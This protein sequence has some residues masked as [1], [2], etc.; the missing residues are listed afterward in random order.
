MNKRTIRL[1]ATL[2]ILISISCLLALSDSKNNS[3]RENLDIFQISD[4]TSILS[5]E[6]SRG[7][8][9]ITISR[10]DSGWTLNQKYPVDPSLIKIISNILQRVTIKRPVSRLSNE[11]IINEINETGSKITV[12]KK[13]GDNLSFSAGGNATK[14]IAYYLIHGENRAY[15][16]EIP[17]YRNYLSGIFE[18]TAN[19]WRDRKLFTSSWRTIQYLNIDYQ[20]RDRQDVIIAFKNRFLDIEGVASMDTTAL[21]NY[22]SQYEFFQINDFLEPGGYPRYD[23]LKATTPFVKLGLKDIDP[24]KNKQLLIYPKIA[25][26][27]FFLVTDQT[28]EMMVIDEKR[29]K[30]LLVEPGQFISK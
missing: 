21:L 9:L 7:E 18:L 14:T 5:I 10:T 25:G 4:T 11:D 16:V 2:F 30:N 24:D 8:D 23:S 26:E 19:Q 6:I 12:T 27:R 22:L 3:K 28:N 13:N 29:M 1:S 20:N 15:I 17:G